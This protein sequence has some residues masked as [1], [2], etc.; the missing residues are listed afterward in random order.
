MATTRARPAVA[1]QATLQEL[2]KR[3]LWMHFTRMG[4]FVDGEV[5]IIERG[6]GAYVYDEH[7]KR[8]LDGLSALFCV[9]AGHGRAELGDAAA[10][11]V[12]EL[13]F[14]ITWSYAHP[15]AIELATRLASLAPGDLNRVF[16]TSGGS[17]AVESA[18]KVA[19]VYHQQTGN[20]R[21]TKFITREVAYHG[22]TLGALSATGIPALRT[23]FEPLAHGGT[24]VPNTNSYRW[25]ADR[26]PLWAADAIEEKLLF[27][28]PETVAAVILE[29][30]QNAGGSIPPQE[31][32]FQRLREICDRHDVL[33][34]SDEVICAFGRLGHYF[35]CERYGYQPDIVTMAKALTSA[36]VPMGGMIVSDRVY[37]PFST[38]KQMFTH[39]FTFGGHP[40]AAA[41]AMANLDV[42]EREDLCGHVLEHEGELRGMLDGLSDIP[43]VGDV[44][45]DGYFHS[46]ELVKDKRTKETFSAEESE[47]LLRGFLSGELYKR[48]LICRADDRGDPVIQ[49]A[50]PLICGPEHFEEIESVLRPVLTE[51]SERANIG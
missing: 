7:G 42:F 27:E 37:E 36:Y 26:D 21:K 9:N 34:I 30:L 45:G 3:H 50:P 4:A 19:R 41:V 25:P 18:I 24:H 48:G 28:G 29:P 31:G 12:R 39:G 46:I 13:D 38:G 32:Y 15:R 2:A 1:D 35:G 33:L 49:L 8:Y 23:P 17:E 47:D 43:I 14:Y 51:A 16:F 44:R 5:P 11:Q 20:P 6:E 10:A 40:V 22:T